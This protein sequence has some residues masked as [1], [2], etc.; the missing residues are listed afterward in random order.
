L[1]IAKGRRS[2]DKREAVAK[3]EADREIQRAVRRDEQR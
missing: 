1:G 2:F 3:R